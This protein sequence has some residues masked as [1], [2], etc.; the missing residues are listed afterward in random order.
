MQ[1]HDDGSI[2][3][4][5]RDNGGKDE[6]SRVLAP[7]FDLFRHAP[8]GFECGYEGSGPA[9]LSIAICADHLRRNALRAESAAVSLDVDLEPRTTVSDRIAMIL[10]Q[11]FKRTVVARLP[12]HDSWEL[13][14]V[15]VGEI[16]DVLIAARVSMQKVAARL[17]SSEASRS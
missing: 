13:S 9:Q 17:A 6:S 12:R 14:D 7:R 5:S 16:L 4:V 11:E 8:S 10:H 15:K 3:R 1:R 2:S